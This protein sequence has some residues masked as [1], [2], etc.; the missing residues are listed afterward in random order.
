MKHE[1][2]HPHA[3]PVGIVGTLNHL[4]RG[5]LLGELSE[6]ETALVAAVRQTGRKGKLVLS[7]QYGLGGTDNSLLQL[8]AEVDVRLP[9]QQIVPTVVYADD[10]NHLHRSDPRQVEMRPVVEQATQPQPTPTKVSPSHAS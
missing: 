7:I 10:D 5:R 4:R 3:A 2:T 6:A 9:K 8:S 1:E